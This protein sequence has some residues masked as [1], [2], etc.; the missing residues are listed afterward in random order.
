MGSCGVPQG[1]AARV[2]EKGGEAHD[3]VDDPVRLGMGA[4]PLVGMV[5]ELGCLDF[6]VELVGPSRSGVAVLWALS[7]VFRL[8]TEAQDDRGDRGEVQDDVERYPVRWVC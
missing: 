3:V 7:N 2:C 1:E 5:G 4:P 8:R 6:G